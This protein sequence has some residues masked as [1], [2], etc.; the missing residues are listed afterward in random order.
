MIILDWYLWFKTS[1]CRLFLGGILSF[2]CGLKAFFRFHAALIVEYRPLIPYIINSS[3]RNN[4]NEKTYMVLDP[5]VNPS[6]PMLLDHWLGLFN[7][8]QHVLVCDP[9]AVSVRSFCNDKYPVTPSSRVSEMEDYAGSELK[10][11]MNSVTVDI[12]HTPTSSDYSVFKTSQHF[13]ER[14]T[15]IFK[16]FLS[17]FE[18][19][20]FTCV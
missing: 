13:C 1:A 20:M 19:F 16:V 18:F 11:E 6:S 12:C 17:Y 10:V 7:N 2:C 9:N 4:I 3:L 5:T 15:P 8:A 14:G